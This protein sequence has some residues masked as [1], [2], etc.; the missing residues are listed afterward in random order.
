MFYLE[1]LIAA[2]EKYPDN[3]LN[4]NYIQFCVGKL[5]YERLALTQETDIEHHAYLSEKFE[6]SY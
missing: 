1:E 5:E 2:I 6:S 4:L 3:I